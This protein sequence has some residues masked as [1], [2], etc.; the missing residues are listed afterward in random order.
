MDETY[1]PDETMISDEKQQSDAI[2]KTL[3]QRQRQKPYRYGFMCTEECNEYISNEL[4]LEE[5]GSEQWEQA[6]REWYKKVD[7][8]M[9]ADGYIKSKTEPCLCMK[10]A[11]SSKIKVTL[12]VTDFFV[13]SNDSNITNDLENMLNKHF[14]LKDLGIVK[15]CLGMSI[16]FDK[17]NCTV[18]LS[19]E[20]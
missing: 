18:T 10:C 9:L 8:C 19:Q 3:P 17:Q 13:F 14:M 1:V 5:A 6:F 7:N 20:K 11:S 2:L 16:A 12:Y 4:T 15:E